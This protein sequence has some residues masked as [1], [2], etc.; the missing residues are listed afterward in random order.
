MMSR[1][2]IPKLVLCALVAAGATVLFMADSPT[3]AETM[4]GNYLWDD[5]ARADSRQAVCDA[6][7]PG[8]DCVELCMRIGTTV[9]PM[10]NYCCIDASLIGG[11]D[12]PEEYEYW[13]P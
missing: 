11:A 3:S 2:L 5:G 10:D 7:R 1:R 6:A 9:V 8:N 13:V 4:A 12:S